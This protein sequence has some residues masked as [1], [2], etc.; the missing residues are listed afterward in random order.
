MSLEAVDLRS[1]RCH[2]KCLGMLGS[3]LYCGVQGHVFQLVG[4]I[5]AVMIGELAR[6]QG[7]RIMAQLGLLDNF[8]LPFAILWVVYGERLH[9]KISLSLVTSFLVHFFVPFCCFSDGFF[10][11]IGQLVPLHR[12]R[13]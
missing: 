5:V 13:C 2:M 8:H 4:G 11:E 6:N 12:D 3:R 10:D 9:V 7:D 1:G